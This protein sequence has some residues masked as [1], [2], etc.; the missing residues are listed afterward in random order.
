VVVLVTPAMWETGRMT[1]V[2]LKNLSENKPK[3]KD[4]MLPHEYEL[5]FN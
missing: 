4:F 1:E 2:R 3:Q 5:F